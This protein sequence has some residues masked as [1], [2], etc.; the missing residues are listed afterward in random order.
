MVDVLVEISCVIVEYDPP[1]Y[2][3]P[4]FTLFE[5]I[6]QFTEGTEETVAEIAKSSK[7]NT[8]KDIPDNVVPTP[9]RTKNPPVASK[10]SNDKANSPVVANSTKTVKGNTNAKGDI[11]KE[12]ATGDGRGNAAIGN[13]LKGRGTKAGSQG[14]GSGPGNYGDPLGGD[15]DGNSLIGIDRN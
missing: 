10:K 5:L 13:L 3:E 14:N 1:G 2:K 7:D 8:D 12:N 9:T 6:V 11:K 4:R 15:G